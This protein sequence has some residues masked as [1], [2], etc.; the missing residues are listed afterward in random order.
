MNLQ[1]P[2]VDP[3]AVHMER[4]ARELLGPPILESPAASSC[5]R[6]YSAPA[7]VANREH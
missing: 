1:Q 7:P 4:V 2:A 3:L 6:H 5:F